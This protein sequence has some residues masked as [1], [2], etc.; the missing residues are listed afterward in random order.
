MLAYLCGSLRMAGKPAGQRRL[1]LFGLACVRRVAHRIK[2]DKCFQAIDQVEKHV[3]ILISDWQLA[4][5]HA[6]LH[7]KQRGSANRAVEALTAPVSEAEIA[8]VA[9]LAIQAIAVAGASP[10]D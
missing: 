1:R 5:V 7:G 10:E 3:E 8:R 6:E 4:A 2:G 9:A